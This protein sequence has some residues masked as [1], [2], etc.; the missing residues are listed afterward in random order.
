MTSTARIIVHT[1]FD[2]GGRGVRW[3]TLDNPS[4]HN[5][6]TARIWGE[7]PKLIKSA[8]VDPGVH[9]LVL[10]GAGGQAFSA[11]AD[12]TEFENLS[13]GE[14][15][16]QHNDF[17]RSPFGQLL[18]CPKPTIAMIDG[19]CFGGGLELA[20][21]C[22]FRIASDRSRFAIPAAKLGVGYNARWIKPLVNV[23]GPSKAKEILMSA[24]T[25]DAIA[26]ERMGLL[27]SLV[28]ADALRSETEALI[29][30]LLANAPLT[31]AAAKTCVDTLSH[32]TMPVEMYPLDNMVRDCFLSEDYVE[33]QVA[34]RDKRRPRFKGF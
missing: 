5:T 32:A 25:Y 7:L 13:P 16:E 33:G 20:V 9:V 27:T 3:L 6:L 11:G 22:D 8:A 34:F 1:D 12:I 24:R 28:S 14:Q 15:A 21:C 18:A 26:A 31:M 4:R 23:V 19:I 30:D 2:A 17:A 29:A 10:T